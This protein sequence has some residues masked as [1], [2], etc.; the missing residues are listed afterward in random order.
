MNV[1]L[2]IKN[3]D[4]DSNNYFY[5]YLLVSL[6]GSLII[7]SIAGYCILKN[8]KKKKKNKKKPKISLNSKDQRIEMKGRYFF[9]DKISDGYTSDL[10][11]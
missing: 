6:L 1:R 3:V 7:L 4:L 2:L 10:D 11:S 9:S 5:V 8:R